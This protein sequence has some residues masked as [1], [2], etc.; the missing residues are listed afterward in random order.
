M[1][2]R[3]LCFASSLVLLI[4]SSLLPACDPHEGG[5]AHSPASPAAERRMPIKGTP[6]DFTA[7]GTATVSG[8]RSCAESPGAH[9]IDIRLAGARPLTLGEGCV[10]CAEA[11]R[12]APL[13][14]SEVRS[15]ERDALVARK[16]SA[17]ARAAPGASEQTCGIFFDAFGSAVAGRAAAEGITTVGVGIG[18]GGCDRGLDNLR[19]SIDDWRSTNRLVAIIEEE[20]ARWEAGG[21][22]A[23]LVI[24]ISIVTPQ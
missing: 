23:V 11:A 4:L 22:I 9:L 24:G 15:T 17:A 14:S 20:A 7:G 12:F 6:G 3:T 1:K 13:S 8:P 16:C 18:V 21:T 10:K 5:D 2:A 19:F